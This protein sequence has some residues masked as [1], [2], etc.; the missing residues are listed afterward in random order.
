[1]LGRSAAPAA[2]RRSWVTETKLSRTLHGLDAP[3]KADAV[4]A[5]RLARQSFTAGERIDMQALANTL[6]VNRATLFRWVGNRDQLLAEVLWSLAQPA[7]H[8][9][10]EQAWGH[11]AARVA[12]ALTRFVV[13]VSAQEYFTH[14]LRRE[15]ERALRVLTT[16]AGVFRARLV[17]DIED[18]LFRETDAGAVFPAPIPQLAP[19]VVR[20]M[21]SFC[22]GD[23]LVGKTPEPSQVHTALAVV[24][25]SS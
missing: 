4:E 15:P 6:G 16:E 10:I 24:L 12:D 11:G 1:M 22:Y 13:A 7:L 25:K 8:R 5:F 9:A 19:V 18:L 17:A 21:E 2:E 20:L 3:E 23:A 14:F